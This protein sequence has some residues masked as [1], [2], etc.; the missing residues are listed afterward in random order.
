S[1]KCSKGHKKIADFILQNHVS[2]SY[3]TALRLAKAIGVSESTVVRFAMELGFQGYPELQNAIKMTL[4]NKLTSVQRIEVASER[5]GSDVLSATLTSDIENL[6]A[7]LAC[8]DKENFDAIVNMILY[9]KTIYI[10]GNRSST[11]LANFMYF[12]FSLIFDKAKLVQSV[13]G[14]DIFEQ[15]LNVGEGDLIIG[16][17][18]PRY[19]KRTVDAMHYARREGAFAV[20]ITDSE[21]SPIAQLA[22]RV[23][24]ARNDMA[25][26]VDSLVAPLSLINALIS[27]VGQKKKKEISRSFEKLEKIWDEYSIYNKDK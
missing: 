12:Y 17:S 26:F 14:S 22:D 3:M 6:K 19:S 5:L 20:A 4:K 7:T 10:V 27:A 13:S 23:L 1:L 8:T 18:F 24:F 15:M 25:S 9:A 16:I 11:S 2:A 21:E